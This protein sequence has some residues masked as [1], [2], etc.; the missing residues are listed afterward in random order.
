MS[1]NGKSSGKR[2][3]FGGKCDIIQSWVNL[4]TFT[5]LS[6]VGNVSLSMSAFTSA[7]V[8]NF[9]RTFL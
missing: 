9:E 7:A 8:Y 6:S 2:L 3:F 4:L 5:C 1:K